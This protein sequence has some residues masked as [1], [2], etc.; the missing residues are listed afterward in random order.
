[1][2]MQQ[3]LKSRLLSAVPVVALLT[4]CI[5]PGRAAGPSGD[6]GPDFSANAQ[7]SSDAGHEDVVD[8]EI[9]DEGDR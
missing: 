7:G 6:V 9:V 3:S 8:A 1:M 5:Q 2:G 4:T